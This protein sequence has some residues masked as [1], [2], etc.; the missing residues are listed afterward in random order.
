MKTFKE[1]ENIIRDD[2]KTLSEKFKVKEI[3]VFGSYSRGEESPVSDVDIL[4]KFS[5]PVGWEFIDLKFYLEELLGIDVDL[6]TPNSLKEG[7]RETV[8]NEVVY[9]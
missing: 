4:V 7:M 5:E 3:G 6:A 1:I 9:I 2:Q 8:L